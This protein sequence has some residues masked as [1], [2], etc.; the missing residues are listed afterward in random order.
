MNAGGS[1]FADVNS[2]KAR[3]DD[4]ALWSALEEK[5]V[6]EN[7]K[8]VSSKQLEDMITISRTYKFAGQVVTERKQVPVSSAEAKL[9]LEKQ[10]AEDQENKGVA[11]EK[12]GDKHSGLWRPKKRTNPFDISGAKENLAIPVA[13]E[14]GPRLNVVE[15]SKMDWAGFVDREG[16][17]DQ[18]DEAGRAKGEYLGRMDFLNRVEANKEEEMRAMR[19]QGKS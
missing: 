19:M 14:S 10:A 18:L 11:S 6:G 12:Q 16:I 9:Y 3:S 5:A 8:T 2:G 1:I 13:A 17:K 7:A 4:D 15:K